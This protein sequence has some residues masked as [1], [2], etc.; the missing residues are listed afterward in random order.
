MPCMMYNLQ[1]NGQSMNLDE[2]HHGSDPETKP[3]V[4]MAS[5]SSGGVPGKGDRDSS[6]SKPEPMT[7]AA[8]EEP[9]DFGFA[10][11]DEIMWKL[12]STLMGSHQSPL[13]RHQVD[14]FDE[15]LNSHF[16]TII[17][18]YNPI[19]IFHGYTE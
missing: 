2:E 15:F 13:V 19:K 14:S 1:E 11:E 18:Q 5:E 16:P 7:F 12:F 10:G 4:P 6:R 17:Q 3:S 8:D 9:I